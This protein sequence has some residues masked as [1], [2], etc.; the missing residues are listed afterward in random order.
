MWRY[1]QNISRW[2]RDRKG[3]D[4]ER[5]RKVDFGRGSEGLS[6]VTDEEWET[7]PEVGNL[8]RKKGRKMERSPIVFLSAIGPEFHVLWCVVVNGGFET[9]ADSGTLTNFVEIGQARDKFL[10]LKLDQVFLLILLHLPLAKDAVPGFRGG[11][12]GRGHFCGVLKSGAEIGD[13]KRAR[14][15]FD[16]LVKSNPIH[17]PGWIAAAYLEGHVNRMV[18][19]RKIIKAGCKQCSK[20][21]DVW[22][23]A[24]RLH[25]VGQS[26]K[27]WMAAA[28]LEHNMKAKK[29][30][31]R[32]AHEHI[33][34]SNVGLR[35]AKWNKVALQGDLSYARVNFKN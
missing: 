8:T 10:S 23:E 29:R 25:H 22:L 7:L 4:K 1:I 17:S 15:L 31:L 16:S 26:V 18:A 19:V 35:D 11:R 33:P 6:A 20:S 27:I 32:K 28:D 13:I 30:V 24:A 21:E 12:L 14:M 3:G 5:A 9:P 2:W 34:N